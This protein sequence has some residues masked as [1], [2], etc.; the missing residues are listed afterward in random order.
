MIDP[1]IRNRGLTYTKY[2]RLCDC[3]GLENV[4]HYSYDSKQS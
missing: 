4:S 2:M 3:E 1:S